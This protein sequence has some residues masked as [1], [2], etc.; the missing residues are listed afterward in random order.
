MSTDNT[1]SVDISLL[2]SK[3]KATDE[4]ILMIQ[5]QFDTKKI[6]FLDLVLSCISDSEL[7]A[8]YRLFSSEKVNDLL[9]EYQTWVQQN[10]TSYDARIEQLEKNSATDKKLTELFKELDSVKI[11]QDDLEPLNQALSGKRNI[12]DLINCDDLDTSS[13]DV[14]I[15]LANLSKEVID[16]ITGNTPVNVTAAP[17]GGWG[18]AYISNYAI[19]STKLDHKY[20]YRGFITEG[21]INDII[22]DGLYLIGNKI[23]GLPV[24]EDDIGDEIRILEVSRINEYIIQTIR[25]IG[26]TDIRPFFTRSGKLTRIHTLEFE[27]N[28]NISNNL[29]ITSDLMGDSYSDR[30]IIEKGN[31]Y[32]I[33]A[34]G[35]YFVKAGVKNTPDITKDFYVD[36][37]KHNE[38]YIYV[39]KE[40]DRA[41]CLIYISM[42]YPNSAGL[43][44]STEWFRINTMN[45]SEY[46]G[47]KLTIFGD[48][49]SFGIGADSITN[50]SYSSLLSSKYGFVVSNHSIAEATMGNYD[51]DI[52]K[53]KSIITQVKNAKL[54]TDD[55]ILIFAGTND[56]ANTRAEIGYNDDNTDKTFKGSLNII[57]Q[58]ILSKNPKAKILFI[59]PMYR[60]RLQLGDNKDCDSTSVAYRY[61]KDYCDAIEE[62]A[63]LHY[64]IPVLNLLNTCMINK[65]NYTTYLK[66]GLYP[67][68]EGHELLCEK[69]YNAIR[70][71]Y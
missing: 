48:G 34:V 2:N 51:N 16:A 38:Q 67:N 63:N 6:K 3:R 27:E 70:L 65:Y 25:Y 40:I 13:D 17:I 54:E 43:G 10:T 42:V 55:I 36:I 28:Y 50:N 37:T 49:I 18:T 56:Y 22:D 41:H 47:R 71:Y 69:I 5:D 21:H 4:D 30:G 15:K 33:I 66:D 61:L 7:P 24:H 12:S 44:T 8:P 46:D 32:D 59:T 14:K 9:S 23:E 58:N 39:A 31:L 64:H 45:K 35:S 1:N 52:L 29:K 57:I 19:T 53:E 60:A 68:D 20:R 26:Q 11:E 62:I